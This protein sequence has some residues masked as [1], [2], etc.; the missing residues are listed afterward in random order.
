LP[1]I[2]QNPLLKPNLSAGASITPL[3]GGTVRLEIPPGPGGR[4]RLAQLDDYTERSRKDFPWNPPLDVKLSARTSSSTIPGTWGFGLWN[5]PFSFSLG[6]GGGTRRFPALPN[7]VWFF[8]ASPQNYLSLQDVHPAQG[9][10]LQTFR[11]RLIPSPLLALG[12]I[13]FPL[14][15]LP[16]IMR[17]IRLLLRKFVLEDVTSIDSEV[18]RWHEY[19]IE[20]GLEGSVLFR[21]DGEPVHE[22]NIIPNG[23]LGMVLWIDNQYLALPPNGKMGYGTLENPEPAWLEIKDLM[24]NNIPRRLSAC[25]KT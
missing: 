5:D 17:V 14:L 12:A 9:F 6:V 21:V 10:L 20:W 24:V 11:S 15:V 25:E 4:Y 3:E 2:D 18:T 23:P 16:G 7:A 1:L 22:T 19:S 13:G 8:F